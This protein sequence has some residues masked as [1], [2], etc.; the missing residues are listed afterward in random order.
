MTAV[1][2]RKC[3]IARVPEKNNSKTNTFYFEGDKCKDGDNNDADDCYV[4]SHYKDKKAQCYNARAS[5]TRNSNS[6][7]CKLKPANPS[8]VA[9]R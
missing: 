2:P 6:S 9:R 8:A 5:I 3:A 4:N 7:I 1:D